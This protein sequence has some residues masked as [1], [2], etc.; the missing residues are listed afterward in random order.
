[1]FFIIFN[2]KISHIIYIKLFVTSFSFFFL[3]LVWYPAELGRNI[4][5]HNRHLV[6]LLL[7]LLRLIHLLVLLE[8]LNVLWVR[9]VLE[10][11]VFV[12]VLFPMV[13]FVLVLVVAVVA[14]AGAHVREC[15]AALDKHDKLGAADEAVAVP[16]D[17]PYYISDDLL[18]ALVAHILV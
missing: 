4:L 7:L 14:G 15:L 16:V 8:V 17:S 11:G 18:F 9:E 12:V 6:H 5:Q 10:L 1:M 2:T 3:S 13:D